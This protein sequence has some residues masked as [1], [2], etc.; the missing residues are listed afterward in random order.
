MNELAKSAGFYFDHYLPPVRI[1]EK[2]DSRKGR[3]GQLFCWSIL[4]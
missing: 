1:V 4:A 2:D 3:E